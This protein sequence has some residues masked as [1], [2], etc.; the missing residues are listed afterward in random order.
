MLNVI[1]SELKCEDAPE[2]LSNAETDASMLQQ[3]PHN[4]NRGAE[5]QHL[6]RR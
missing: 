1:E 2:M 6:P 5:Q 4:Q 3:T